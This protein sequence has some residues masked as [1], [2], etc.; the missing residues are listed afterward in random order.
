MGPSRPK[1]LHKYEVTI[2]REVEYTA[3]IEIE[4]RTAGE[5]EDMANNMA[6]EPKAN[7]WRE[8]DVVSHTTKAKLARG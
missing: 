5:A 7:H 3:V 4:A 8:G 1:K 2:K 6:D